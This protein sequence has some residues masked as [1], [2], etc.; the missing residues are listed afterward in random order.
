MSVTGA[1]RVVVGFGALLGEVVV[2]IH[3]SGGGGGGGAY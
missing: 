3:Y 1:Q 2:V